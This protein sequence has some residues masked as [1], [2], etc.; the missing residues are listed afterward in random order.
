MD[1][2][3]LRK[4]QLEQ[5]ELAKEIK[6]VCK[7]L[8]IKYFLD[9]GTLLGA[10]R[11][12]GFIPWDDDLDIGMLRSDYDRFLNEAPQLLN[13]QFFL[14]SWFSD[15]SYGWGF[16]KLRKK[17][18]V[19]KEKA[20]PNS[21]EFNGFYIDIFPYD[22]YPNSKKEQ[23][24]QKW[25]YDFYRRCI[26]VKKGYKPWLMSNNKL[27]KILKCFFYLPIKVIAAFF[28]TQKMI[29]MFETISQK[30]NSQSTEYVFC[31]S[32]ENYAKIVLPRCVIENLTTHKF[33]DDEFYIPENWDLYLKTVYGEYMTLPPLEQRENRH[34]I[35]EVKFSN[36]D[37]Q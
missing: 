16:A 29:T 32:N 18:T 31:N 4:V 24:R 20:A 17:D 6:R 27:H 22:N 7:I 23:K 1:R 21:S 9:S 13:K 35:I 33:E 26:L 36:S 11:H 8:G 15:Q 10:I 19:Y 5:L 3:T 14:Q 25:K 12:N 34:K 37:K 30:H 2:I 28:S